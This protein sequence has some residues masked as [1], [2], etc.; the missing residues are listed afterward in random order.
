MYR[1]T[2]LSLISLGLATGSLAQYASSKVTLD[3]KYR[4]VPPPNEDYPQDPN[5]V[6]VVSIVLLAISLTFV[7]ISLRESKHW[8]STVPAAL[9]IGSVTFTLAEAINC[10][11]GNVYWTTSHDPSKLMSTVLG[12]DFETYVGIIWWSYGAVL[13]CGIFGAL[14]RNI[15][16]G[17]L[18]A[19]LG[20][21]GFLDIVLEE[22]LLT[23]GG[24]YTY[25][26][27]Q[28]L[29]FNVFPLWWA[30]CNVSSIFVGVSV[31]YRYRHL[32]EGW[33]SCFV[34]ILLPLCYVGPQVLAALPTIYAIQAD[35]SAFV[36][37]LCG[38]ATCVLAVIQVGV[39]MDC[40]LMRDPTSGSQVGRN[41]KAH[42][43]VF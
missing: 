1:H 28:P 30:F 23:Y 20:F 40:V 36:T 29:V 31:A 19:L 27:H 42:Q 3:P 22:C 38:I 11:L 32:L 43:K 26:G 21:A 25:Y 2:I 24:V 18:W 41:I 7:G 35:Y 4:T 9:T 33:G 6:Q 12:R 5:H 34:P 8:N 15:G 17:K 13:S 39:V 16:T 37:Q 14:N 10:Y